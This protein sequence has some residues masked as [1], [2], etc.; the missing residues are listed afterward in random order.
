MT[1][2]LT[3][4]IL[5]ETADAMVSTGLKA[6]GYEYVNL[7]AALPS[8]EVLCHGL[9]LPKRLFGLFCNGEPGKDSTDKVPLLCSLRMRRDDCWLTKDRDASGNLQVDKRAFPDG[10]EPVIAHVHS[11]GLCATPHITRSSTAL[12]LFG[13]GICFRR[14]QVY[15]PLVRS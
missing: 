15:V 12:C 2:S 1:G 3:A 9:N 8:F 4:Q 7:C 10:L 13:R 6:K 14:A 5:T 11:K